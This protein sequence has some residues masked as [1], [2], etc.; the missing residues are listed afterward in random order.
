ME[1]H[2]GHCSLAR[3]RRQPDQHLFRELH[4][5]S[6]SCWA[7][8]SSSILPLSW[9]SGGRPG[10]CPSPFVPPVAVFSPGASLS[11]GQGGARPRAAP[12]MPLWVVSLNKKSALG[13]TGQDR[14]RESQNAGLAD[15]CGSGTGCPQRQRRALTA[16][17]HGCCVLLV[18]SPRSLRS[19][20]HLFLPESS[21]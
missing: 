2:W 7:W 4:L 20:M 17:V 8:G 15:A 18:P 9:P 10:L 16:D 1:P 11:G 6:G 14:T 13:R 19:S 12:F 21:L 3:S 5:A